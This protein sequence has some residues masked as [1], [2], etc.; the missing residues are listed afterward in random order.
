MDGDPAN[1]VAFFVAGDVGGV[2][3]DDVVGCVPVE[4][5]GDVGELGREAAW[6]LR[7]N[8]PAQSGLEQKAVGGGRKQ[9][10]AGQLELHL[11]VDFNQ[12]LRILAGLIAVVPALGLEAGTDDFSLHDLRSLGRRDLEVDG[13]A[14][15][16]LQE[17]FLIDEGGIVVLL[18]D[19][20]GVL[21]RGIAEDDRIRLEAAGDAG[22]GDFVQA[23]MEIEVNPGARNRKVLVIDRQRH[24]RVLG[25]GERG[26]ESKGE[27]RMGKAHGLSPQKNGGRITVERSGKKNLLI[28]RGARQIARADS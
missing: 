19:P 17:P 3:D 11:A 27:D 20:E 2:G 9:R 23:G 12:R 13:F 25:D 10:G 4:T 22:R 18:E 14:F 7:Q 5:A 15:V 1:H 6:F 28:G 8:L 16:F 24:G 26:D 21:A